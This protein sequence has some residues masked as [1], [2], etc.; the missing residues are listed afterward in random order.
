MKT[1]FLFTIDVETRAEG[2]L[3]SDIMGALPGYP[4]RYGIGKIMETLE[5]ANA[6]GTFFLNVYEIDKHGEE[7]LAAVARLI[8]SRG[9]DVELHTHPLPMYRFYGMS[10]ASLQDQVVILKKGISLLENWIGRRV[11]AHRA[12]AFA[13]NANTLQACEQV[14]LLADSSLSAGSRVAVPLVRDF[15][16]TNMVRRVGKIWEIPV[17]HYYPVRLGRWHSKRILDLEA[18]SLAEIKYVTRWAVRQGLP[19]I[20][21]LLHSF[22]LCRNGRP[23]SSVIGRLA[24]LL[25]WLRSQEDIEISTV[26]HVCQHLAQNQLREPVVCAPC[27][28]LWL[29]WSRVICSWN[30][31]WRNRL[32]A[33]AGIIS[34]GM[35]IV[36]A[37][38]IAQVL[39]K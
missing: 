35:L 29:T 37:I 20:C 24:A 10:K 22:S 36:V 27:T 5:S 3:D 16:A 31:G 25:G 38:Y 4:E 39:L 15:G 21:L 26:D 6:R 13:A 1:S 18:C 28:G 19:T 32:M 9:H 14:G 11:V 2:K 23:N 12:G 8:Q 33:M 34:I 30:D 7:Q 17:T